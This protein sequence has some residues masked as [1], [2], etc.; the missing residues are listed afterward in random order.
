MLFEDPTFKDVCLRLVC[1]TRSFSKSWQKLECQVQYESEIKTPLAEV[2]SAFH[3]LGSITGFHV[4]ETC[5][6][7]FSLVT[8]KSLSLEISINF[9]P[10]WWQS[11]RL[12]M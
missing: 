2:R 11:M 10:T 9:V 7:C 12:S 1:K 4:A 3:G 5:S 6:P 8:M